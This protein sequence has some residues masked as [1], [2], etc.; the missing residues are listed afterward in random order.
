VCYY[1]AGTQNNV[2]CGGVTDY[3][4]EVN[5][6]NRQELVRE[7]MNKTDL[8]YARAGV[9][10]DA[11]LMTITEELARGGKVALSGFGTFE[12]KERVARMGIN[13]AT[14]ERMEIG[15]SKL[16]TFKAGKQLKEAV[17]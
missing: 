16:P 10:V 5:F 9:A 13:P 3:F 8:D 2:C 1:A 15:A 17:R 11:V 14:K 7:L 4:T 6:M 12:V